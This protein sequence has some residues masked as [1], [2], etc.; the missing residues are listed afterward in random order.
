MSNREK[1]IELIN[2]A[3][4]SAILYVISVLQEG[5]PNTETAEAVSEADKM[6]QN[7]GGQG[8]E[9]STKDFMKIITH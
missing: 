1:A 6:R 5:A 4:E 2:N 8:F 9:G 3:N 7:G